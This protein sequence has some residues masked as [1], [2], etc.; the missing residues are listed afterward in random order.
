MMHALALVFALS[1][2]LP[3]AA[4]TL[5][6]VR[7]NP[8]GPQIEMNACAAEDYAAADA[9]L[10]AVWKE[11]LAYH[12]EDPVAITRLR[13]AQRA[14]IAFRDAEV[15]ARLPVA[16]GENPQVVHGSMYGLLHHGVLAEL[17][18]ERTA[19]LR[20]QLDER[21]APLA[22]ATPRLFRVWLKEGVTSDPR[23]ESTDGHPC[24]G[25]SYRRGAV[26]PQEDDFVVAEEV[27]EYGPG[28]RELGR[29]RVPVDVSVYGISGDSILV[30][31]NSESL[32][33][34]S[35]GRALPAAFTQQKLRPATG[36]TCP[37]ES[38]EGFIDDKGG[39]V[40]LLGSNVICS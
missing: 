35:D 3:A 36:G 26:V 17:T 21:D 18:R 2:S 12:A 11:L 14:W 19:Q 1:V 4:V 39:E 32:W 28:G 31:D 27:V 22:D 33:I 37:K 24:G 5:G 29:W 40:R 16:D 9:E 13:A 30:S 20:T 25:V 34:A 10:N 8:E 15:A 6:D 38:C 23:A 7:C